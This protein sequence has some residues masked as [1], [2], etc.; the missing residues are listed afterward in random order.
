MFKPLK[1][2]TRFKVD[3]FLNFIIQ[4]IERFWSLVKKEIC[5]ISSNLSIYQILKFLE[6]YKYWFLIL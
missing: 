4:N 6:F 3:L 5:S 2:Q 1:I